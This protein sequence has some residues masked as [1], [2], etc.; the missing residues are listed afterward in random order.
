MTQK[1]SYHHGDLLQ[2][3]IDAALELIAEKDVS[4]VS[5]REIARRVGVSHAAPYRHFADKETLLVAVAQEGL[6]RFKQAIEEAMEPFSDP[7][8]QLEAGCLAYIRYAIEHP[9]RYRIIFGERQASSQTVNLAIS[10]I[11]HQAYLPF[12][13]AI[14]LGQSAGILRAGDPKPIAQTVWTLLHGLA[15]LPQH[16]KDSIELKTIFSLN[17]LIKGL[18]ERDR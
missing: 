2:S 14:A 7:L 13:G 6:L 10:E 15:M 5:L 1:K 8:E 16:D 12:I 11:A 9:S 18:A 3:L 17:I 4:N